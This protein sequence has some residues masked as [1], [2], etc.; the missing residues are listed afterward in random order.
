[1]GYGFGVEVSEEALVEFFS[2]MGPHLDEKQ[3]RL[4]AGAMARML[5]RGGVTMAARVSGMGQLLHRMGFSLQATAS[6]ARR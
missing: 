2:F 6:S 3:R 1:M 5:G 4:Q